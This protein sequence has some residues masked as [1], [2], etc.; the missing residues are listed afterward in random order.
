M[1]GR[2]SRTGQDRS[3][4][5]QGR[6]AMDGRAGGKG[7]KSIIG[8]WDERNDEETNAASGGRDRGCVPA[9]SRDAVGGRLLLDPGLTSGFESGCLLTMKRKSD[10]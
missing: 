10:R 6:V 5:E 4:A 1:I 9:D 7:K 2:R 8:H 3:C